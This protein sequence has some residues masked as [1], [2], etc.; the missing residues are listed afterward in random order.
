MMIGAIAIVVIMVAVVGTALSAD[1]VLTPPKQVISGDSKQQGTLKNQQA[2]LE[3]QQAA[4]KQ[5]AELEKQ[6]A[7]QKQQAE[8]EKQQAELE[9]QQ[10]AKK[11]QAELE[12]QQAELEKRQFI[13]EKR[14]VQKLKAKL[15][16]QQAELE[17]RLAELEKKQA[18]LEEQEATFAL[19]N[20]TAAT[21]ISCDAA[22][23]II[24]NLGFEDVK[25]EVCTGNTFGFVAMRDGKSFSIEILAANGEVKKVERLR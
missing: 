22:R 3:K 9:K 20:P 21:S 5:Q 19:R 7:P 11:Q 18:E 10:P 6:Q 8:L 16:K 17:K 25:A 1:L 24:T 14:A 23:Q 2:E 13:L 4:K 15:E 12:K